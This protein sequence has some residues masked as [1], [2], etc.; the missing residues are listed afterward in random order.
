MNT[1]LL[2]ITLLGSAAALPAAAQEEAKEQQPSVTVLDRMVVSA[3]K[4]KVAIGT[5]QSVSV[6]D[7]ED[8]EALQPTTIGDVLTDLPGVKAIGSDRILGESFNIRGIGTL[9]SSDE[10]RLI[11]TVDGAQKFHEQYRMGSLFSDPELYKQVEVLRGPASST[12]YGSGALAGV[13]NLTTKDAS[14]YLTGDKD[15]AFRQKFEFT[16]NGNGF[17]T[18]SV[19][20][21][22]PTEN[23]E[24][25]GAFNYRR[26][27]EFED[28]NGDKISGSDFG[29]PSGM[30]KGKVW[31]GANQEHAL[32]ASY[33]HWTTQVNGDY[34]Q[35]GTS[36]FGDVDRTVVDQTAILGYEYLPEN[37]EL[38]DLDLTL[39]YTNSDVEQKNAS[40]RGAFGNSTLFEPTNYAYEIWQARAE[41]TADLSGDNFENYLITGLETSWQTRTA[42]K[43]ASSSSPGH[44]VPF[45]PGGK[46]FRVGAYVQNEWIYKERLSLIPG[47]RFDWQDLKPNE[48][49]TVTQESVSDS[50]VSPKL[51]AFYW[52]D[53]NWG[54]FGSVAYTERL[55][56]IDEYFDNVSSNLGLKPETS[57]NYEGG[58]SFTGNDLLQDR[59]ALSAKGTVFFNQIDNLIERAS[60]ADIYYN[61]GES[62]IKGIELEGSYNSRY[63]FSRLAY[64]L[65]RG[66]N[67][68]TGEPLNSIPADELVLTV[69]GRVP[70]ENIEFGWRGVFA[71]EQNR[72]SGTT[73][74]SPGYVVHDLF[75]SWKPDDGVLRGAE[76]RFGID[77]LFNKQY[78]E[79]L[80]GD[81]GKGRTFKLTLVKQF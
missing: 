30:L 58:I 79:H 46:S 72:V 6:V 1:R 10:N 81:P 7:Q 11:V 66:E 77:N 63:V 71:R 12:L 29:A 52:L 35:T 40:F 54:V 25:L 31:F 2:A 68:K 37:N 33:Q 55:P 42:E 39:S 78:Q 56:V 64:T 9:G 49:V 22:K 28:G 4:E 62:E 8:M 70:D 13:I 48:D 20:A 59:D 47:I 34:S 50:A 18:S 57:M 19:G 73:S 80:A 67:T 23:V 36:G 17:L 65:L 24:L 45:H 74:R 53:P 41:N 5:A 27:S 43:E 15:W 38:V 76:F 44:L 60:T 69:G 75:S 3:G 32:R 26:S 61:V 51:A 14:D 21:L 16:D